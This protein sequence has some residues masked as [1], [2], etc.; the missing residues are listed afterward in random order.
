M[1]MLFVEPIW[2][3]IGVAY[4]AV[5]II[6]LSWSVRRSLARVAAVSGGELELSARRR[7]EILVSSGRGLLA[8]AGV[9]AVLSTFD[10]SWRGAPALADFVLVAALAVP[11]VVAL[12][13]ASQ[14]A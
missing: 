7:S 11:G 3:G 5:V 6:W 2:M 10:Y 8:A 9:V 4:I 13:R 14:L 1:A 12:R